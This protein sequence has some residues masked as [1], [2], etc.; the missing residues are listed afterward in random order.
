MRSLIKDI[1]FSITCL[2]II[3]AASILL[4]GQFT[5]KVSYGGD[6]VGTITYMRKRAERK[7]SEQ[8][9]WEGLEK[10]K[11][12]LHPLQDAFIEHD[13]MQCGFCTSGMIM[14]AKHLLDKTKA[15][16]SEDIKEAVSGNLCRCR[17][18]P[19]VFKAVETAAKKMK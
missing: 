6:K 1:I 4:Y 2:A 7:F 16:S 9:I 3:I 12:E 10:N 8:V 14:S 11:D 15:P 19:H 18:Y 5:E 17:T 13:A